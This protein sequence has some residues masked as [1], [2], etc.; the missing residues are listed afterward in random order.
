M[1][2][3]LIWFIKEDF[4]NVILKFRK[5]RNFE[6]R[7]QASKFKIYPVDIINYISMYIVKKI[8]LSTVK[9]LSFIFHRSFEINILWYEGVPLFTA[10]DKE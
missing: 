4:W 9:P 7:F 1:K 8:M 3:V 10:G 6:C 2:I 5:S